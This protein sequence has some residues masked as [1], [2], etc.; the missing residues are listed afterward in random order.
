MFYLNT[1]A[2]YESFRMAINDKIYIDKTMMIKNITEH[3]GIEKRFICITRPRRFGKSMNANMLA[4]FYSKGADAS[5]LFSDRNISSNKSC[6]DHMNKHN[7]IHISLNEMPDGCD[8]YVA[9]QSY[10]EK[11]LRYDLY[12]AYPQLKELPVDNLRDLLKASGDQF[13]FIFDE[14]DSIFYKKFIS[15]DDKESYLRFLENLLKGQP[16][17]ELAYMTG[18]LPIAKYSSGSALNM[19]AQY[20]FISDPIFDTYFGFTEDEVQSLCKKHSKPDYKDI[21]HWYDGYYTHDGRS[22]FNPRSVSQAFSDG[23]CSNYWTETGPMNEIEMCIRH[24]VDAVRDDIVWLVSGNSIEIMLD[25]FSASDQQLETR[26]QILSALVVYGLLS[27]HDQ[28]LTIPNHELMEKFNCVLSS[29]PMI[30]LIVCDLDGTLFTDEKKITQTS[31]DYIKNLIK[32]GI[33]FAVAS[34]RSR[35]AIEAYFSDIACS[36]VTDN[37]ARAYNEDAKELFCEIIDRDVTLE[38]LNKVEK[39][40]YMNP[41]LVGEKHIYTKKIETSGEV[42]KA[43]YYFSPGMCQINSWGDAFANDVI[44][45]L[46][47]N[48]GWNGENEQSGWDM[49]QSLGIEGHFSPVLSGD[50]WVELMNYGVSKGG[51]LK[52]LCQ[53]MG[54]AMEETMVFGDY[55]NDL[56]MLVTTPNSYAMINGHEEVKKQ[57]AYVTRYSNNEDGVIRAIQERL[58]SD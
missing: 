12:Q 27:Y 29:Q 38:I 15:S 57:C 33:H 21:K 16:Y 24:N 20:S 48:T 14:W 18:V 25:G 43:Q 13:I 54:I 35:G 28:I 1:T 37:G 5:D 53:A 7:V 44:T 19:F 8:T 39:I 49:I 3:I 31:V 10:I 6:M 23:I 40:D 4:A 56:N 47:I 50:G 55:L 41:F 17:V 45:K 30:K 52:R 2:P 58:E 51:A 32:N 36:M 46:S 26:N 22:L 42:K 11:L 34:G 9:F